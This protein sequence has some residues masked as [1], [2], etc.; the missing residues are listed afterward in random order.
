MELLGGLPMRVGQHVESVEGLQ[1]TVFCWCCALLKFPAASF[2]RCYG[3][4]AGS[5]DLATIFNQ[6]LHQWL[7]CP[8]HSLSQPYMALFSLHMGVSTFVHHIYYACRTLPRLKAFTIQTF[9]TD[10]LDQIVQRHVVVRALG[11]EDD[12]YLHMVCTLEGPE[13][14]SKSKY[15]PFPKF[16]TPCLKMSSERG[17]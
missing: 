9:L 8:S 13:V 11:C 6:G 7:Q 12:G 15:F 1:Q 16:K 4:S 5:I 3:G 2:A 14:R 17:F 10:R